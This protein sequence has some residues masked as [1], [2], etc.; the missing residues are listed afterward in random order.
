MDA[1]EEAV[2]N[3][4]WAAEDTVGREGRIVPALPRDDVL[5]LLRDR[6]V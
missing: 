5:A 4:L 3:A 1:T 2:V 6:V